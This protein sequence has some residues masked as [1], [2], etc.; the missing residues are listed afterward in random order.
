MTP[1]MTPKH[2]THY[3]S[4]AL[5]P[6]AILAGPWLPEDSSISGVGRVGPMRPRMPRT[7][8]PCLLPVAE[9]PVMAEV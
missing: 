4:P 9:G 5:G 3:T 1:G 8:Q 2:Y 6:K 7:A